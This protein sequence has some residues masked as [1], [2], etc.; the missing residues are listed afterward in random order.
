M[1]EG[2]P[3]PA[4]QNGPVTTFTRADGDGGLGCGWGACGGSDCVH[5]VQCWG[6]APP[7]DSPH[8]RGCPG[9]RHP[10]A[11]GTRRSSNDRDPGC[12]RQ[13]TASPPTIR[14]SGALLKLRNR[15]IVLRPH[16]E[17]VRVALGHHRF[18][19]GDGDG[20][21]N[22]GSGGARG[23]TSTAATDGLGPLCQGTSDRA[24]GAGRTAAPSHPKHW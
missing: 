4:S 18:G 21:G 19:S 8:P 13:R 24:R 15:R 10:P 2:G 3:R 23:G 1:R 9:N 6:P 17:P 12:D 7:P 20:S 22:S 11:Q 14:C 16:R 5:T